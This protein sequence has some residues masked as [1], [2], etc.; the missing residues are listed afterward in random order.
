MN[1]WLA[2]RLA[3]LLDPLVWRTRAQ[4]ARRFRSFALAEDGSRL[5]LL[6]AA[7]GTDDPERAAR[8]LQHALD[9]ARHARMF[10]R[11]ARREDPGVAP[12]R[13]DADRLY[14]RLGEAGFL[15]FVHRGEARGC[16]QFAQYRA[17]FAERD[18]RTAAM[19]A[20]ILEDE[21]RHEAYTRELLAQVAGE[22]AVGGLLRRVALHEAGRAWLRSGRA[23]TRVLWT[24][25]VAPLYLALAPVAWLTRRLRPPRAGWR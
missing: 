21:R 20:N 9:E 12:V 8:Y 10:W 22:P 25:L 18:P 19:L 1:P 23:L 24:A 15:A 14:E 5:D 3:A 16:A 2:G 6:L 4:R 7:N 13:A 17:W 11:A